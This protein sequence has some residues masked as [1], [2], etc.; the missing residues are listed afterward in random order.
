VPWFSVIIVAQQYLQEGKYYAETQPI[1]H[2]C[3]EGVF[4]VPGFCGQIGSTQ[5][6]AEPII[7]LPVYLGIALY[8]AGREHG[9][10]AISR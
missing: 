10:N 2:T 7:S 1:G 8:L 9:V 5:A 3:K 4:A 6:R